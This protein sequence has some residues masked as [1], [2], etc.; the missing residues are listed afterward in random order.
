MVK[1]VLPKVKSMRPYPDFLDECQNLCVRC[2][3]CCDGTIFKKVQLEEQDDAGKLPLFQITSVQGDFFFQQPC[4]AFDQIRGCRI[5]HIRP[6]KCRNFSCKLLS[7]LKNQELTFKKAMALTERTR[8]LKIALFKEAARHHIDKKFFL[9][10]RML[11]DHIESDLPSRD[12]EHIYGDARVR[13]ADFSAY[14]HKY[15]VRDR[16]PD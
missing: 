6:I 2:G 14:L 7:Q 3:F 5:Y 4:F 12:R 11:V 9:N 8:Q 16:P 1:L 15:F 10:T 13:C